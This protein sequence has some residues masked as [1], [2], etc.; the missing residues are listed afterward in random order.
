MPA[1]GFSQ[2]VLDA[3]PRP[4]RL[5]NGDNACARSRHVRRRAWWAW[6][7]LALTVLFGIMG[8]AVPPADAWNLLAGVFLLAAVGLGVSLLPFWPRLAPGLV[9]FPDLFDRPNAHERWCVVCG[10]VAGA[11][12]ACSTCGSLPPQARGARSLRGLLARRIR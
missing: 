8:R 3:A 7:A 6:G 10:H 1:A 9:D 4:G 2:P 11:R 5:R 12:A